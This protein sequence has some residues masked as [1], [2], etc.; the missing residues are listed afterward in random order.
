MSDQEFDEFGNRIF[1]ETIDGI[2]GVSETIEDEEEKEEPQ[3]LQSTAIVT[4]ERYVSRGEDVEVLYEQEDQQSL[5]TPL[6][7][8]GGKREA[9]HAVYNLGKIPK[10]TYDRQYLFEL[11]N[12]PERCLNIAVVGTL[13]SGKTSIMDILILESHKHL[14]SISSSVKQG[15]K[16]LK[17]LDNT[18]LEIARGLTTKLNGFTTLGLDLQQK[19]WALTFL[20][21]PGHSAFLDEVA[22]SFAAADLC[23]VVVDCV[24]GV[25]GGVR[26]LIKEAQ[27]KGLPMVFVLNKIDRLIMELKLPPNDAFAKLRH[28]VDQ[29][30]SV[31]T[32]VYSPELNNIVFASSKFSFSFTLKQFVS[33]LYAGQLEESQIEGFISQLWGDVYFNLGIF[34]ATPNSGKHTTFVEFVLNPIYKLFTHALSSEPG[35]LATTLKKH[36]KVDLD[37]P[38]LGLDPLPLLKKV[39]CLVFRNQVGL[40]D[41][42]AKSRNVSSTA[43]SIS[44]S[45]LSSNDIPSPV[46][47]L[48]HAVRCVD[49]C[50]EIW[51]LVRVHKGVLKRGD[52]LK[53]LDEGSPRDFDTPEF[54][55]KDIA[56]LGGRYVVPV[57]QAGGGQVV[58][59]RGP[60]EFFTKSAT[61][62][63]LPTFSFGALDYLNQPVLKVILQ[64]LVA[65]EM[66]QMSHSLSLINKL[67]PGCVVNVEESG[68]NVVF[69]PAELFL[70]SLLFELR[71][72][73]AGIEV[74]V[75]NPLSKFSEGCTDESFAS[76]PVHSKN[77]NLSISVSAQ[78]MDAKLL[79][80]LSNGHFRKSDF[81]DHRHLAKKLRTEY[82]WDSLAARNVWEFQNCNVFVDD[83]LPEQVDKVRVAQ[84]KE[85]ILE[86][87]YWAVREGP[88][89]EEPIFGVHF[90]LIDIACEGDVIPGQV[91]PLVRRACYVALLTAQPAILEPI[92]EVNIIVHSLASGVL[93]ELFRKRRGAKITRRIEIQ[94]TP[95]LEIC[96]RIPVIDSLG[97]ETDLRLATNGGGMCQFYFCRKT[98][99]KVPGDVMDEDTPIPKLKP[100]P[101][102]SLSRDFVMKTRRRK[103]L[104][105]EGTSS[106][107][108]PSLSKYIEPELF[109]KLK[110]NNLI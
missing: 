17:Y 31:T 24:E 96:G 89:A 52:R 64:P 16:P 110:E 1:G 62:T 94:G 75:S 23:L 7:D 20:D 54:E 65:K 49:Y 80:D 95:L 34:S 10:T 79:D 26:K 5:Q 14:P 9:R 56:L 37:G 82:G 91:I 6:I 68:E 100:A 60:E 33:E 102:A 43:M 84:L 29:I 55:I 85:Q 44:A 104:S 61:L 51:A 11:L 88:L 40:I 98:W 8:T 105:S 66:P 78:A 83:T 59:V 63:N 106:N 74:K 25:T 3:Q 81:E 2:I 36:F 39:L 107:D 90:R 27:Q 77:A 67:Y 12:V 103:G 99:R 15:W 46:H 47:V 57:T 22:V 109:A 32:M 86:G 19:S 48:A 108:G 92:Y 18:K 50:G 101:T 21:T 45:K 97:F 42:L 93:D 87:F 72:I 69:G 35:V 73:Y 4:T 38:D 41:V 53:V 58:L 70:D 76:I 28:V 30:N 13:H 71:E